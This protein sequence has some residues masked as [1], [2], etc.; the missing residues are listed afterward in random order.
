MNT[1]ELLLRWIVPALVAAGVTLAIRGPQITQFCFVGQTA[2]LVDTIPVSANPELSEWDKLILAISFTESRWNPDAVGKAGD[3][4]HLQ[5]LPIY[6]RE[7]NRLYGTNYTIEDAFDIDLSLQMF[8]LMQMYYNP[9][10]NLDEAIRLHNKSAA[11]RETVL[12]NLAMID[13]YEVLRAK[14]IEK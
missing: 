4:G 13:R 7:V 10:Q 8:L 12:K 11:Y 2:T 1:R 3:S 9:K 6:V 14:L 5:L